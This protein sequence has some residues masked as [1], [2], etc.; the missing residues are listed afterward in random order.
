MTWIGTDLGTLGLNSGTFA[1]TDAVNGQSL[2]IQVVPEPSTYAL[3]S[4]L[5]LVGLVVSRRRILARN[6]PASA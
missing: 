3:V 2:Q 4:G 6:Q 1:I 5:L